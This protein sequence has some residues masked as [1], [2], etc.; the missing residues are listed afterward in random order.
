MDILLFV[1]LTAFCFGAIVGSFLN[2]VILRLPN[3]GE[4][5]VFPSSHCTSCMT[6]LHWYENI[7]VLSFLVLRGKCSHCKA[8]ISFQYP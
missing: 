2:V 7:P 5:V 8:K 4:S 3:E 6:D 1:L